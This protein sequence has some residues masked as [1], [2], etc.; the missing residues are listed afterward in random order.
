MRITVDIPD[1]FAAQIIPPGQE[2]SRALLEDAAIQS[3]CDDR[4]TA[5]QLGLILGFETRYELDGF[6]KQRKVEHGAYSAED[7]E[8]DLQAMDQVR[9][10]Q[11]AASHP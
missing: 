8:R 1:E 6:L 2:P 10:K 4:I 9:E 5:H 7:L 11:H 3:Y